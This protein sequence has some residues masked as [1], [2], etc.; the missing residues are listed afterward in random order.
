MVEEIMTQ[1]DPAIDQSAE[2]L[3]VAMD[4]HSFQGADTPEEARAAIDD[5]IRDL[6]ERGEQAY[7]DALG[8]MTADHPYSNA[9][10]DRMIHHLN[11]LRDEYRD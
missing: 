5:F 1:G 8:M 4:V 2:E 7:E 9:L 11:E 6:R 10:R 3:V